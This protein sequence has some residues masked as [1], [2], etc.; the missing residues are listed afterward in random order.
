MRQF[1]QVDILDRFADEFFEKIENLVASKAQSVSERVYIFLQPN[2]RALDKDLER[3]TNFLAKLESN[4]KTESTDRLIKW[5][6]ES[7][8]D[9][10]EKKAARDLSRQWSSTQ[11]NQPKM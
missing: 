2:I 3:Y 4:A 10:K 6:K 5:V 7:I 9:L 8:Q 11:N 1:S